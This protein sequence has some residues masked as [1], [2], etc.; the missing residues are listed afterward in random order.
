MQLP[1]V[2]EERSLIY[3]SGDCIITPHPPELLLAKIYIRMEEEGL[4]DQV[5][6]AGGM[7]IIN[8]VTT[9]S[10]QNA[11]LACFVEI[12]GTPHLAGLMWFN[13]TFKIGALDLRKA[14]VGICVFKRFHKL[15][16]ALRLAALCAEWAFDHLGVHAIYGTTPELNRRAVA[17]FKLLGFGW[18]GPLP[19]YT[20]F[21]GCDE[22]VGVYLSFMDKKT[23]ATVRQK[24]FE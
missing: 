8:F 5:F 7:D 6:H 19:N 18:I 13:S 9:F 20:S 10:R 11:S 22:P 23:W 3:H 4:L 1:L 24:Y 17:F 14:E 21:P 2:K 16:W 12:D 15:K